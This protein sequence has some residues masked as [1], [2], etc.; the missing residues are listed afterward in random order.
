MPSSTSSS[1]CMSPID[2]IV[3][4]DE[5]FSRLQRGCVMKM[6]S[7]LSINVRNF[8]PGTHLYTALGMKWSADHVLSSPPR[9]LPHTT[10]MP[11]VRAYASLCFALDTVAIE[12]PCPILPA[13]SLREAIFAHRRQRAERINRRV[14]SPID[15]ML[16]ARA[17]ITRRV[18]ALLR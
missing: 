8:L 1:A 12:S 18:A 11:C 9:D 10:Q 15:C 5:F 6:L 3:G 7:A 16:E 14:N 4:T 17:F 13:E 2:A